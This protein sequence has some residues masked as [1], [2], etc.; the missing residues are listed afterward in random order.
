MRLFLGVDPGAVSGAWGIVDHHGAYWS[1]GMIPHKDG[2]ILGHVWVA[3]L[4]QAIDGQ[5][6]EIALESVHSMPNQGVSST[7][8]FGRAVGAIEALLGL[9]PTALVLVRPQDWK[10]KM[11]VTAD[12]RSSLDLARK[13]WHNAPLTRLKDQ[14]V[15]EA[16]LIA[17]CLR[18]EVQ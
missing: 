16:L 9:F 15:A 13:L 2:K 4:R 17:E 6:V 8:K 7:F 1:S 12:K 3:E 14:N 5:D 18:R 10:K 11:G